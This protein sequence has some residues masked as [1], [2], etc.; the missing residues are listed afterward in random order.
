V[1]RI[2][3]S[4]VILTAP[5]LA[6]QSNKE[7][8]TAHSEEFHRE[9]IQVTDNVW[10]AVG[11][12][13]ANTILIEGTDGVIIVDT[14]ESPRAAKS[15]K[16]EFD[17]ITTKPVKA[18]I[19][20]HNHYDHVN[21]TQT[22][23]GDA[24]PNVYAHSTLHNN[25]MTRRNIVGPSIARRSSRQFGIPLPDA[26]RPNAGIGPKLVMGG[27]GVSEY[28]EPTHTF[29]ES[30]EIEEAGI[31]MKLVL[32]PGETDDQLY[33]WLPDQKM[34]LPGDNIYKAFPNLYAV[35]GTP[36][37]DVRKWANSLD[38]MVKE[39]PEILVPSHTRPIIGKERCTEL[40][41]NYRDA[42][43]YVYDE[44]IKGMN[45]GVS[46]DEL[47]LSI[48]LPDKLAKEPFLDE[49][50]GTI[51]WSVKS[52]FV[53][54]LGW[55][56][57]NATN[58]FPMVPVE[59]A[60]AMADLAGGVEALYIQVENAIADG[61]YIWACEL[62]DQLLALNHREKEVKGLKAKALIALAD[63]QISANARNYY[64]TSAVQLGAK[65]TAP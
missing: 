18:V 34:L 57:G 13:L 37:R 22:F 45:A 30:M 7:K 62:S 48:H 44:T 40:L 32:A 4:L 42:I 39:G 16:A 1:I 23:V 3:L 21:G 6:Q 8:L 46:P 64:L 36:Y 51:P 20:T 54:H 49:F 5:A 11:Y 56:D 33:V 2:L 61:K 29:E 52:I 19:Y 10:V 26:Q 55:F 50:Y 63:Q 47:A 17:K 38:L 27:L 25:V 60:Q 15:I 9:V 12:A 43:Q 31:K 59:R 35:R 65:L 41:S 14:T 24:T 58:L 53:G 28:M